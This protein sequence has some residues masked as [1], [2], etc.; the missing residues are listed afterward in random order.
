MTTFDEQIRAF[1]RKALQNVDKTMRGVS[2]KLFSAVIKSSPV[3][4]GRFRANWQAS[5]IS[6]K[7]GK[8]EIFDKSGNKTIADVGAYIKSAA[9]SD[10]FTLA[11]NLPYAAKLEYGAHSQ[12]APQG[13]VRVNVARFQR[14]LDEAARENR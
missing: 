2:I 13:M 6:A 5:G 12:Q 10:Q 7:L 11:N 8:L 14:L 4:T 1:Q 3:D 9:K